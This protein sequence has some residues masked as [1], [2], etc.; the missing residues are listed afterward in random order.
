MLKSGKGWLWTVAAGAPLAVLMA[1]ALA[2]FS[3]PM[4]S[5]AGVDRLLSEGKFDEARRRA[6]AYIADNPAS[7]MGNR[8][9]AQA[10]I[11]SIESS[12][13]TDPNAD[14]ATF[15]ADAESGEKALKRIT[16]GSPEER[17]LVELEIGKLLYYEGRWKLAEERWKA[18]LALD[19]KVPE[20]GWALLDLYYLEGRE[21]EA[22]ELAMKLYA[23]EPD[24]RD[25][26]LLL[27]ELVRRDAQPPDPE[28]I[29]KL[30]GPIIKI[31]P[32]D[33][34]ARVAYGSACVK[35]S[36]PETGLKILGEVVRDAPG[37][38]NARVG[39]LN[40]LE[41]VDPDEGLKRAVAEL[42]RD[43]ADDPKLA[44]FAGRIAQDKRDWPAA[45][46]AYRKAWK[47]RPFD[48]KL[49][50]RLGRA[51][52]LAGDA[53]A[54]AKFAAEFEARV[55]AYE[56]ART[57]IRDLHQ[58]ANNT[59]DLGVASHPDLYERLA[60]LRESMGRD[61]EARLWRDLSAKLAAQAPAVT[62]I[63]KIPGVIDEDALKLLPAK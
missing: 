46:A 58:E 22:H 18:A 19:P 26:A 45:I 61:D 52:R 20:A 4:A 15:H 50:Y 30:L 49:T 7:R 32:D 40:A 35:R 59:P 57:K 29:V 17:A 6:A 48:A 24:P 56:S 36:D 42:P 28:S 38:V 51:L 55:G 44:S 23:T 47:S 43:L 33:L 31:N 16:G 25:R 41:T 21:D 1:W 27:L 39:L 12:K 10:V 3:T 9:Y 53:E 13:R 60:R 5:L 62:E 14:P 8:Y 63:P 34:A 37:D 2:S 11:G 54:A